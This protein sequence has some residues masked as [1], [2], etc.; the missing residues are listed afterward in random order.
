MQ[1]SDLIDILLVSSDF[2]FAM[3]DREGTILSVTPAVRDIFKLQEGEVEGRTLVQLIPELAHYPQS[4]FEAIQPR[5][6]LE[7]MTDDAS[8]STGKDYL[9]YLAAYEQSTGHVEIESQICGESHWLQ[10]VTNKILHD[11][12]IIFTVMIS[13]I[14][15]RK[16]DE[17]ELLDLN[18]NLEARVEARTEQIKHVVLSCSSELE[19][20]NITYQEMKE[21]Q[22]SIMESLETNVLAKIQNLSEAQSAQLG[23]VLRNELVQSMNLYSED[24]ITDQKFML[25]MMSLSELFGSN[26]TTS[27]NLRPDQLGGASQ[28]DVDD[29]LD[30]LGI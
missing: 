20:V 22:M 12:E 5:G 28:D 14:T 2:V 1:Q 11:D 17:L 25:T 6:G 18:Q 10:L 4:E 27:D 23:E 3:A 21:R 8:C 19:Q 26:S 29:L 13:D 16:R 24:Q 15:K 9:E 7:L 30:S